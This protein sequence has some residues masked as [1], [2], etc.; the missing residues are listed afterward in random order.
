MGCIDSIF[1]ELKASNRKALMPFVCAGYPGLHSMPDILLALQDAGASVVEVGI[2]FSDPIA[3]GPV[4]AA[5]MHRA[6]QSGCTPGLVLDQVAS[7]R[8]RIR[9]GLVAM[10]SISIMQRLGANSGIASAVARFRDAGFD[11]FIFPD[12]PLE[13]SEAWRSAAGEAG[14]S[15]TFLIA[16][17][18][19]LDRAAAIAKASTGFLYVLARSGITGER[20]ELPEISG[21]VSELRGITDL[22]IAVGF[23]I[24][25][26]DQ[27]RHVV[28][29]ADAA[30]VGS[31]LIRRL[32][33]VGNDG[34][35]AQVAGDFCRQLCAGLGT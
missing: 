21:R 34:S 6:I 1:S 26:P 27:V 18:T 16:P 11:G 15:C 17:T 4:I 31:A 5:A 13:E 25:S 24:S 28:Q 3:D 10:V 23:G 2:P 8:E 33:E 29:S 19:P 32:S 20:S 35:P 22:P 30:I 7:V 14:L 12:L 9:L